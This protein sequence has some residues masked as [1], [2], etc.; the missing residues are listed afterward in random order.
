M[1]TLPCDLPLKVISHQHHV[2]I[3]LSPRPRRDRLVSCRVAYI[4]L[5]GFDGISHTLTG[6]FD[7]KDLP[8][9]DLTPYHFVVR[10]LFTRSQFVLPR[11]HVRIW[12]NT[13]H[14]LYDA[15]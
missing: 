14:V 15:M 10:L 2:A 12:H 11:E 8:N 9:V 7:Q 5:S 1:Q 6:V 4:C 13:T 3:F